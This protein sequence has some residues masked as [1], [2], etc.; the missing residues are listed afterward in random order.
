MRQIFSVLLF[1]VPVFAVMHCTPYSQRS[2]Q[3]NVP[4]WAERAVW[5]Q[6]YPERFWNGDPRNDPDVSDIITG[7]PY[8]ALPGWRTHPWTS[9]WYALSSWEKNAGQDFY[10]LAGARRYGGDLQGIL[11]RLDYLVDLGVTAIYFNPLFEAPSHH[12]YDATM[13]HHIDN[14]FGPNPDGDKEIWRTEN[15]ADPRTWRWT[16]ADSLFLRLL[17][18]CHKNNIKVIIDGVFNHV[19]LTFWA[20]QDVK[21]R[22]QESPYKDWFIINSWDDEGTAEDEFNYA[23]WNG[24]RELPEIREDEN[25]LNPGFRDHIR[26]VIKRWMDPNGDGNPEDG[27][28]GWRLDVAE[29]VHPNFWRIFRTWV[30]EINPDA[31]LVGEIWWEDWPQN[32][33]FNAA[34]WLQGDI[35]D[36]VMNYRTGR[37]IKKHVVDIKEQIDSQAF[38]DSIRQIIDDYGHE[39]FYASQNLI[40][41]HDIERLGSQI[42]NP[43]RW[44]DH[45]G[46]PAQDIGFNIRK[47]TR[48][49]IRKQK[50]VAALQMTLPGAP[51]IYYGD[52][53]GMWGGDDPD[54]RKPMLWS[55]LAYQPEATHPRG[56]R[57]S[58]DEVR[59]NPD[60]YSWY[61]KLIRMRLS[62][63]VLTQGDI[64]FHKVPD[65]EDLLVFSRSFEEET[66]FVLVNPQS[67]SA[68]GKVLIPD[69]ASENLTDLISNQQ[70]MIFGEHIFVDLLPFQIVVLSLNQNIAENEGE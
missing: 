27:V 41:S 2:G 25:G 52:E 20:F 9:D 48:L 42:V 56:M 14:N 31:Y 17:E 51:M 32:K 50:L 37:A 35:F 7:W 49:E 21:T 26:H 66:L 60:L 69:I 64:Q 24:V 12:K 68:V 45:G 22:Q 58:L 43:D 61:R 13:Y 23:G 11:D 30:K 54:C 47:P 39:H 65:M 3:K 38:T 70:F 18:T 6:I 67:E 53:A 57:R 34:P 4:L 5:Y 63:N 59:F 28:D 1:L 40:S 10:T 36:G 15:P 44:M 62:N 16:S 8:L 55:E 19:G 46:N 29:K 33:M